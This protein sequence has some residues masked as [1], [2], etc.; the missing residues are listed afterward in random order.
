MAIGESPANPKTPSLMLWQIRKI[1]RDR[2]A[3]MVFDWRQGHGSWGRFLFAAMVSAAFWGSVL[4]FVEIRDPL[5]P[6]LADDEVDLTL[7][8]L[9]LPANRWLSDLIE[10]ET[11]L[12]QRWNLPPSNFVDQWIAEITSAAPHRNYRPSIQPI[13]PPTPVPSL[14]SLPGFGPG[15]LPIRQEIERVPFEIPPM[16]WWIE[17]RTLDGPSTVVAFSAPWTADGPMSAGETWIVTVG[18][19]RQGQVVVC[20]S[21]ENE[22][23]PRTPEILTLCRTQAWPADDQSSAIRWWRLEAKVVSRP[24]M[25]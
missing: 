15:N 21:W 16:E 24:L 5:D 25:K 17:V 22:S 13:G 9:D 4:A 14:Q 10:K 20:E 3:G 11:F 7:V 12:N 19:N 8:D 2:A 18:A 1:H 23:D 6:A